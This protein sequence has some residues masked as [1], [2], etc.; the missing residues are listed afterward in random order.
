ELLARLRVD[1]S[2]IPVRTSRLL[3]PIAVAQ[4][5]I[6]AWIYFVGLTPGVVGEARHLSLESYTDTFMS[7]LSTQ[8]G[9]IAA[10]WRRRGEHRPPRV[11]TFTAGEIPYRLPD[12]RIY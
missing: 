8:A 1:G 3:A 2:A 6:A 4:A 7:T 10:D 12:A 5:A 11:L 9:E